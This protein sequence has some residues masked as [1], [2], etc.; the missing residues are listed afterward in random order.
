M[1]FIF[2]DV[3]ESGVRVRLTLI[4]TPGFGDQL[5]NEHGQVVH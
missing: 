3:E 2:K 5:N 1:R 4:D